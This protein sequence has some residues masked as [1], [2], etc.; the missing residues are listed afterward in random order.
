MIMANPQMQQLIE[1]NPEIRHML[2]NPELMRQTMEFA[3]NPTMMQEIMRN[4]GRAPSNLESVPGGYNALRRMYTDTQEPMLTA[5]REQFGNNPFS[6]PTGNSNS[7]SSQPL[8]TER[9]K[10]P[11][12]IPRAP[13][14]NRPF[15]TP[16]APP[17]PLSMPLIRWG[18]HR[19]V[20]DQ[21][22]APDSL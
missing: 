1:R 3:R 10:S 13:R 14:E 17:L 5:A 11:S 4:Q 12:L 6:S 7:T 22:G 20:G 2:N 19:R 21:L 15:L 16:R 9:I 18:G 8:G